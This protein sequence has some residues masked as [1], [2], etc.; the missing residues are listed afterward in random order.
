VACFVHE[1]VVMPHA[2]QVSFRRVLPSEPVVALAARRF[3]H[4]HQQRSEV[5]E[6]CVM[7]EALDP[8]ASPEVRAQHST[9]HGLV[10]AQVTLTGEQG[11]LFESTG[12]HRDASVALG[13]AFDSAEARLGMF[14]R[15][16][17][18]PRP[19][20]NYARAASSR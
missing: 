9:R 8:S 3:Q 4:V 6:C 16:E 10:Q 12:V 2:M 1:G 11:P 7:V 13:L 5:L 17:L 18:L 15:L 20:A 19:R 14:P